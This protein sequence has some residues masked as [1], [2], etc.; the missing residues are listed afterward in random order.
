MYALRACTIQVEFL[1]HLASEFFIAQ[2]KGLL[3]LLLTFFNQ[4]LLSNSSINDLCDES[5]M[6]IFCV[7]VT[8]FSPPRYPE[9]AA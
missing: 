7:P 5:V 2:F 9:T 4:R 1:Q 3:R 6:D 8:V